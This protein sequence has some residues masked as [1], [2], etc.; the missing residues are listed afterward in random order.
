MYLGKLLRGFDKPFGRARSSHYITN[1]TPTNI[2]HHEH[3]AAFLLINDDPPDYISLILIRS[4]EGYS[5]L[6]AS[7]SL[8]TT[9]L[10]RIDRDSSGTF[11]LR[12]GG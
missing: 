9:P 1:K 3:E 5:A 12:L 4:K 11:G 6:A 10:R 8:L 7:F 2:K